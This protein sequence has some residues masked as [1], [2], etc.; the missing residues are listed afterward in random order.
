MGKGNQ[1]ERILLFTRCIGSG[2]TEKVVFQLAEIYQAAGHEVFVCAAEGAGTH[3]LQEMKIP[4]FAI[5][6]MKSKHPGTILAVLAAVQKIVRQQ[7]ITVVHTHHRMAAFYARLLL[8]TGNKFLLLNNVHNTFEDKKQ[9]TK[10]AFEKACNIAVG[11]AVYDNMI[12]EFD[13]KPDHIQVIYNAVKRPVLSAVCDEMLQALKQQGRFV[14]CNVGRINTQKGFEYYIEAADLLK[15]RGIPAAMLIV[16]E[17]ILMEQMRERVAE[18]QLEDTVF[19]L[20]YRKDVSNV[21]AQSDVAVLS[22]LWEGFPLTPIEVFSVGKTI[23]ATDVPG[24]VEIVKHRHNGLVVPV[25]NG[26]AIADAVAL[27]YEEPQLR[28]QFELNALN[29]YREKFSYEVFRQK[30]LGV[31]KSLR[32]SNDATDDV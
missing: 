7:K 17:G 16:G 12:R 15:Q 29:T 10:F 28:K 8:M 3:I 2:G 19:F 18:Q 20:G 32:A 23:V 30:Y 9:L 21:I 14:V 13:I 6:D 27:L 25:K 24:T 5:P 31:L 26:Q 22:S 1:V 11:E 4:C